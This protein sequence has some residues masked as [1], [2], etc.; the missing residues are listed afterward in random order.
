MRKQRMGHLQT[1]NG[2]LPNTGSTNTWTLDFQPPE[3]WWINFFCLS[4]QTMVSAYGS[5]N[6][7]K[8][9]HCTLK[10]ISSQFVAEAECCPLSTRPM[11]C[12]FSSTQGYGVDSSIWRLT[13]NAVKHGCQYVH[14][15]SLRGAGWNCGLTSAYSNFWLLEYLV[16]DWCYFSP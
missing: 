11:T 5:L 3:P 4:H 16:A 12:L 14:F 9:Q 6:W 7:W 8:H 15:I 10:V 13:S 1:R 2:A